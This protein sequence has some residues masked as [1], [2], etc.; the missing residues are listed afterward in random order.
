METGA[1]AD[2][3]RLHQPPLILDLV[4]HFE[5]GGPVNG[6]HRCN[7]TLQSPNPPGPQPFQPRGSA[8]RRDVEERGKDRE[9]KP[10]GRQGPLSKASDIK[11]QKNVASFIQ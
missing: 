4:V 2:M 3:L 11:R 9:R 7:E 1:R 10:R 6:C 5:E 8:T